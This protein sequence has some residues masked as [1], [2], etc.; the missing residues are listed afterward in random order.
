M[1]K[2]FEIQKIQ[3]ECSVVGQKR[4][5]PRKE[6]TPKTRKTLSPQLLMEVSLLTQT[7]S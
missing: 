3:M 7:K 1:E 5:S 4:N 2:S 6:F